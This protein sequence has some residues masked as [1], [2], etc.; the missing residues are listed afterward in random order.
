[1]TLA[2]D[3]FR[4][5]ASCTSMMMILSPAPTVYRIYKTQKTGHMSIF[6]LLSAVFNC[7]TWYADCLCIPS[8]IRSHSHTLPIYRMLYGYLAEIY[9]PVFTTFAIGDLIAICYVAVFYRA[10]A[11]CA[12][13]HK[14]L[15]LFGCAL[16]VATAYAIAGGFG[17]TGQTR[18]QAA[19]FAGF[20]AI[21]SSLVLYTSPLEKIKLVVQHKSAVFI[22][23]QMVVAGSIN[24]IMWIIY[25]SLTAR[26]LMFTPNLVTL[27]A[28]LFQVVLYFFVYNP[29]SHPYVDKTHERRSTATT[30][31]DES[32][33]DDSEVT[34]SP[35]SN[36]EG[37]CDVESGEYVTIQT[38]RVAQVASEML[39]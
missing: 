2:I 29:K 31:E 23:I 21:S 6:P 14:L 33:Q 35:P 11:D 32:E 3:I 8:F 22:P 19:Q 37:G 20:I 7:H 25:T 36:E 15:A 26:W 13:A 39:V 34:P 30:E 24:N 5:L 27:S 9:F 12:K 28:G 17:L 38:P 16:F 4:V 18:H 10:T 1:M